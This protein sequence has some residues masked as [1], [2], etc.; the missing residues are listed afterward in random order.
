MRASRP[1]GSPTRWRRRTST[2]GPGTYYALEPARHLRLSEDEG[3]VRVGIAHY[4]T[5]DEIERAL[6]VIGELVSRAARS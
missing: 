5:A 6:A 3:V 2:S 1:T 4:N